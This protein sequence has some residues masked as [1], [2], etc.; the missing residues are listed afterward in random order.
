[1]T[2]D[3]PDHYPFRDIETK[4]QRAYALLG[5]SPAGGISMRGGGSA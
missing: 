4:W 1:M 2:Q 5:M 3:R